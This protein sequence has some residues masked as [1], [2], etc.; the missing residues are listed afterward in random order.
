M[1]KKKIFAAIRSIAKAFGIMMIVLL[2]ITLPL[3]I[4]SM[5]Y[6]IEEIEYEKQVL[7]WLEEASEHVKANESVYWE[8]SEYYCSLAEESKT[9]ISIEPYGEM[10]DTRDIIFGYFNHGTASYFENR[11][12]PNPKIAVYSGIRSS[13]E[14]VLYV[15]KD[16]AKDQEEDKWC[17]VINDD[18]YIVLLRAHA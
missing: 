16:I 18:M 9:V 13:Y 1:I 14:M 11:D 3:L 8:F 5:P 2:I 17:K 12:F 6:I 15:S 4:I 10:Q 7:G